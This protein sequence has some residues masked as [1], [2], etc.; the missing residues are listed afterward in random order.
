[1]RIALFLDAVLAPLPMPG[2][3]KPYAAK[4]TSLVN[5]HIDPARM[6]QILIAIVREGHDR[7]A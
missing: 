6:A 7:A 2:R 3:G 5:P 1:M 4:I